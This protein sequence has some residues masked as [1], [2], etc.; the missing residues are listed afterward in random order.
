[1]IA[2]HEPCGQ[3]VAVGPGEAPALLSEIGLG[4]ITPAVV[5]ARS[6]A[7]AT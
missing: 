1:M 6:A 4:S 2:G 3:V 5:S 7:T